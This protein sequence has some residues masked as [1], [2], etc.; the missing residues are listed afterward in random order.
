MCS[1]MSTTQNRCWNVLCWNVRGKKSERKWEPIRDKI[2]ESGCNIFC[3]QETKCESIGISFIRKIAPRR[4][5]QF[6]F[7]PSRGASG[8]ILVSWCSSSFTGMDVETKNFGITVQFT[9]K[10]D[11]TTWKLTGVYGPCQGEEREEFVH[12]LHDL[13]I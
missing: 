4:F 11:G 1:P 7:V 2:E 13:D 5:D 8:G 3:F 12:W 10:H 9:S 6:A